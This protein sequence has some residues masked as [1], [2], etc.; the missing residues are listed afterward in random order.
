MRFFGL[1]FPMFSTVSSVQPRTLLLFLLLSGAAILTLV[2]VVERPH[3]TAA[4]ETGEATG[5]TSNHDAPT[6]TEATSNHDAPEIS[7]ATSNHDAPEAAADDV[8]ADTAADQ[9]AASE[10]EVTGAPEIT[11]ETAAAPADAHPPEIA[12]PTEDAHAAAAVQ[13]TEE[14]RTVA[15]TDAPEGEEAGAEIE[16]ATAEGAVEA[17]E[18]HAEAPALLGVDLAPLNLSSPRF[19]VILIAV[20]LLV[21]VAALVV[22]NP[23]MLV[24]VGAVSLVGVAASVREATQAGEELGLFVRFPVLAAVLFA[25][26]GVLAAIQLARA[27]VQPAE[28][29]GGHDAAA[30]EAG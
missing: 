4:T 24:V 14:G 20:T 23:G 26:A 6:A 19:I 22:P 28:E 27:R 8:A 17:A 15:E 25:G 10:P 30:A 11:G 5:A 1:R 29:H 21:T 16:G 2:S 7:G 13:P 9:P 12:T 18:E 3:E